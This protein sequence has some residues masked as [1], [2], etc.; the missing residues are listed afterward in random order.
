MIAMRRHIICLILLALPLSS[1]AGPAVP[2]IQDNGQPSTRETVIDAGTGH[3]SVHH[4]SHSQAHDGQEIPSDYHAEQGE[5]SAAVDCPCCDD[6]A[7]ICVLSGC[8]PAAITS[9][10]PGI[11]LGCDDPGIPL[12]DAFRVSPTPHSLF[13]PPIPIV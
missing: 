3:G 2:C 9:V 10:S 11:S 8:N 4:G 12:A 13:R 7:T 1:L 6:C 5:V